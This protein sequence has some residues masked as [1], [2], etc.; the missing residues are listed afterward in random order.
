MRADERKSKNIV[1]TY[2][3]DILRS[4]GRVFVFVESDP[5]FCVLQ[6]PL[7]VRVCTVIVVTI[8]LDLF[9]QV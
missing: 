3:I 1:I 2:C 5:S 4:V 8:S 7:L 9:V 6:R